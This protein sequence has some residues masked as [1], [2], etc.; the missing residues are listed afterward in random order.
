[1]DLKPKPLFFDKFRER[2]DPWMHKI[3]PIQVYDMPTGNQLEL[4]AHLRNA[5]MRGLLR[6]EDSDIVMVGDVDEIAR[7]EKLPTA[8]AL[9]QV[10]DVVLEQSY[11]LYKMRYERQ[12]SSKWAGQVVT[13]Y[14]RLKRQS[15]DELMNSRDEIKPRIHDAGWHFNLWSG[16]YFDD[17]PVEK[18][19]TEHNFWKWV[20]DDV[21]L[22]DEA[23]KVRE[24]AETWLLANQYIKP[25]TSLD[26]PETVMLDSKFHKFL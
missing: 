12:D 2:F 3:I 10:T 15:V 11:R 5:F 8:L 14:E 1:M 7:K 13:T 25:L 18:M 4:L 17:T 21:E 9:A 22:T 26:L 16:F 6:A 19:P 20:G 24:D 23:R